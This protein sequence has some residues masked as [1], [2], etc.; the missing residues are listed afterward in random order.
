MKTK[1]MIRSVWAILLSIVLLIPIMPVFAEEIPLEPESINFRIVMSGDQEVTIPVL[2]DSPISKNYY[3][4]LQKEKWTWNWSTWKWDLSWIKDKDLTVKDVAQGSTN[5]A[6]MLG[7]S[8]NEG[9]PGVMTI[10]SSAIAGMVRLYATHGNMTQTLDVTLIKAA[11]IPT[12]IELSGPS[13]IDVPLYGTPTADFGYTAVVY[14]QYGAVMDL[15]VNIFAQGHEGK[16]IDFSN[17]TATLHNITLPGDFTVLAQ[18]GE[19]AGTDSVDQLHPQMTVTVH[20]QESHPS[21]IEIDG[22][23]SINVPQNDTDVTEVYTVKVYDQYGIEMA[24]QDTTIFANNPTGTAFVSQ[25]GSLTVTKNAKHTY[26]MMYGFLGNFAPSELA[27]AMTQMQ[28]SEYIYLIKTP[29]ATIDDANNLI[30]PDSGF[31]MNLEYRIVNA[32]PDQPAIEATG[33]HFEGWIDYNSEE[34]PTFPG[35]VDVE[36]RYKADQQ[37]DINALNLQTNNGYPKGYEAG[38]SITLNFTVLKPSIAINPVSPVTSTTVTITY[39]ELQIGEE[40]LPVDVAARYWTSP[41]GVQYNLNKEMFYK[42]SQ[43]DEF[44]VYSEPFE[45]TENTT[46]YAKTVVTLMKVFY[47]AVSKLGEDF[48]QPVDLDGV[49]TSDITELPIVFVEIPTTTV[50]PVTEQPT[51][52]PPVTEQPTTVPPVTE[53]PTTV[54]PVTEQ[55][56]TV[57]PVTEQPTTVPPTTAAPAAEPEEEPEE[58]PIVEPVVIAPVEVPLAPLPEPVIEEPVN[59]LADFAFLDAQVIDEEVTPQG[60]LEEDIAIPAE[61]VPLGDALPKTNEL[62]IQLLYGLGALISGLGVYLKRKG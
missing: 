12:R 37:M 13:D 11:Q 61:V 58:E 43:A 18:L 21:W 17:G 39:N 2:N 29:V 22:A 25:T 53:Q 52:V 20:K 31:D 10:P 44:V 3:A 41:Y 56:T 51:T 5:D 57:P 55:P 59:P 16:N 4:E 26:F 1:R 62:P 8:F 6:V 40:M 48:Y 49:Y 24:N 60:A 14:D 45:I 28:T 42:T 34:P 35:K 7:A 38:P 47:D 36:L 32:F 30:L 54:P 15:P 50:P 46:I 9:Q 23:N 27:Q 33:R 19:L